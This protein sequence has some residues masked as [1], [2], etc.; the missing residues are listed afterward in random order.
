MPTKSNPTLA[1]ITKSAFNKLSVLKRR[2]LIAEDVLLQLKAKKIIPRP[3]VVLVLAD[4]YRHGFDDAKIEDNKSV[5]DEVKDKQC[6]VCAKGSVIWALANK[7]NTVIGADINAMYNGHYDA[8]E[9]LD[10]K[11]IFG[12]D[13]WAEM[14]AQFEGI[15]HYRTSNIHKLFGTDED[16]DIRER[17]LQS[18]MRNIIDNGGRLKV[19]GKLIG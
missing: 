9:E 10:T 1:T 6:Y 15:G 16:V 7:F 2:V 14:E 5:Q 18:I 3:C 17:T 12:E 4:K 13:L 11:K 8:K 19:G